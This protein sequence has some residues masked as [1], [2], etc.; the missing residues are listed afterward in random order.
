M[1]Q[2][3]M[4][5]GKEFLGRLTGDP[6]DDRLTI[7]SGQEVSDRGQLTYEIEYRLSD[8]W[9]LFGARDRFDSYDGGVKWRVYSK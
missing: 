2:I 8:R 9:S 6:E 7:R 4:F 3:G 5:L 1:Q